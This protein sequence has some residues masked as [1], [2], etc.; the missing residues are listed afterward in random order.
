MTD[1]HSGEAGGPNDIRLT[2]N[3]CGAVYALD[4][5]PSE[6]LSSDYVVQSARG[7]VAG[8]PVDYAGT[9]FVG[10]TCSINGIASPDNVTVMSEY[11]VLIIGEDTGSHQNDVIWAYDLATEKLTRIQTTPYGSETTSP[12]WFPNVNGFGYMSSVVQHPYGESD[13]GEADDPTDFN[14]YVGYIG[15]F[16]TFD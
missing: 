9:D 2:A 14:A 3:D 15:S 8:T 1:G 7:I 16:P 11:G 12:Y 13:S 5:V 10:N 6:S 4:V